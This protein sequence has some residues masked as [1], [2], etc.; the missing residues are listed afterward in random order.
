LRRHGR[1]THISNRHHQIPTRPRMIESTRVMLRGFW[2]DESSDFVNLASRGRKQRTDL[3][4]AIPANQ[5]TS[6]R[7]KTPRVWLTPTA[8]RAGINDTPPPDVTRN[9]QG[10]HL[11]RVR[12]N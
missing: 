8:E 1:P 12:L 6:T 2:P 4:G 5:R 10:H 11:A 3:S 7:D 9:S